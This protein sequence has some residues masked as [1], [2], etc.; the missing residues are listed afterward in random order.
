MSIIGIDF[1]NKNTCIAMAKRNGIDVIA[2]ETSNRLT[3]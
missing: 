3:P 2:N 1:G